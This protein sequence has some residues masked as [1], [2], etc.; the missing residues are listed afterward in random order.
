MNKIIS[1]ISILLLSITLSGC[2]GLGVSSDIVAAPIDGW[3]KTKKYRDISV[4]N[5]LMHQCQ[6]Y[7]VSVSD[8]WVSSQLLSIGIIVLVIFVFILMGGSEQVKIELV[9]EGD[10]PT[11]NEKSLEIKM[12]EK[13]IH[14]ASLEGQGMRFTYIFPLASSETENFVLSFNSPYSEC[15]LPS[16]SFQ[17]KS[18][19]GG[20]IANMGP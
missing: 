16:L 15:A 12:G 6:G 3:E 1:T 18:R 17:K 10:F 4:S 20:G 9:L 14:P 19:V 13:T 5:F 8:V 7:T 2:A 11:P